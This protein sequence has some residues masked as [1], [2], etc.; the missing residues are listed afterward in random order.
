[1]PRP[2][3]DEAHAL[4][5]DPEAKLHEVCKLLRA[6]PPDVDADLVAQAALRLVAN[7]F[8]FGRNC[9]KLPVS[10]IRLFLAEPLPERTNEVQPRYG[11]EGGRRNLIFLKQALMSV[12][13]ADDAALAAAWRDALAALLDLDTTYAWGSKQRRAKIA[14]VARAPK[15]LT[16]VQAA[17]V[18]CESV[19]AD[20]LAVLAADGSDES[21]DA[22]MPHFVRAAR[23]Q[24]GLE[25][26]ERLRTHA[27]ATP[28]V[29]AMLHKVEQL[30]A[31]RSATSPV[32]AL[33]P[34]LGLAADLDELWFHGY[35]SS[36]ATND[37]RIALAHG[38]LDVDSRSAAWLSVSVVLND[39]GAH[40]SSSFNNTKVWR[41]DFGLGT[42]ELLDVP[43][44]LAR[45][46]TA[47]GVAWSWDSLSLRTQLRGRNREA[48]AAWIRGAL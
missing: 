17:A 24:T 8:Q 34:L 10:A 18:G 1:M 35:F 2:T 33:A 31:E 5:R 14:G 27:A 43:R 11:V 25:L 19:S 13:D 41:D 46:A 9:H 15:L 26:L 23:A 44:Y 36:V 21:V 16:A 20:F 7:N 37:S 47:L 48:V 38:Q 6:L 29:Q 12:D 30:L 45:A 42:A 28:A 39:R 3:L 22:L 40:R 32:L 4:L